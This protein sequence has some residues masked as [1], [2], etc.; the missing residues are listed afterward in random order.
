MVI[1][2][3]NSNGNNRPLQAVPLKF[4]LQT[5]LKISFQKNSKAAFLFGTK[6]QKSATTFELSQKGISEIDIQCSTKL[7]YR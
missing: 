5:Q 6:E 1:Q 2:I 4:A 7:S 3:F